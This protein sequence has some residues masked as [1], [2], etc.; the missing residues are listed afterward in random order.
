MDIDYSA[1]AS[2][3]ASFSD[4]LGCII[5]SS[6]GLVLGTFPPADG[7]GDGIKEAWLRFAAIGNPERGFVKVD[8][9]LW[10]YLSSG[11]YA[12]FAVA[13]GSTRPGVLI[14][15]LEQTLAVAGESR[16]N[17]AV[18]R[19][20]DRVELVEGTTPK[21]IAQG[22]DEPPNGVSGT[23]DNEFER[24]DTEFEPLS[25]G[26]EPLNN[27]FEPLDN[28]FEP[29]P[30]HAAPPVDPVAEADKPI[31]ER[32]KTHMVEPFEDPLSARF[33]R[34]V[35]EPVGAEL[36]PPAAES[37]ATELEIPLAEPTDPI[38][39]GQF[40]EPL[41]SSMTGPVSEALDPPLNEIAEPLSI[42]ELQEPLAPPV[43][44]VLQPLPLEELQDP[45]APP[46]DE[47]LQPLPLEEL[48]EPLAPPVDEVLQPL[49]LEEM[50]DPLGPPVDEPPAGSDEG[51]DEGPLPSFIDDSEIDPVA[52]AREFAGLLQEDRR[53]DEDSA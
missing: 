21:A 27:G 34:L 12:A 25:N 32:I 9:Q 35:P 29:L 16:D 46:V 49:P 8:D 51:T 53:S 38:L 15:H 37:G 5:L 14:D 48:Q 39:D 17:L 22:P 47:V 10:A 2:R 50:S 43:D 1:L 26:F 42:E 36:Q 40:S 20:P 30:A 11:P 45:L 44:E 52:L 3:V 18:A 41:G 13:D 7:D 24:L 4:V 28:A 19:P 23:A 31:F 33:A 6:D